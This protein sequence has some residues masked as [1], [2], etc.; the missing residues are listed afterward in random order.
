M[1]DTV[2]NYED[3]S[4]EDF[5]KQPMPEGSVFDE[6]TAPLDED[7]DDQPTSAAAVEN[8]APVGDAPT[9]TEDD[10]PADDA[11]AGD[12]LPQEPDAAATP[13][14]VSED[15]HTTPHH[16]EAGGDDAGKPA[17]APAEEAPNYEALYKAVMAP[18]KA[19]GREVAPTSPEEAV[20]LMQMGAN[21]TRK[22]QS[23]KPNLRMLRMLESNGLLDEDKLSFLIDLDKKQPAA[24][25][26][27]LHDGKVDP[28]DIDPSAAPTYRPGNYKVSDQ[29]MGF[30]DAL[31]TVQ[32]N[33]GGAETIRTV[34]STW[35]Q[36]SK[37]EL[38]G[39][40]SLLVTIDNHRSAGIYDVIAAEV[41]R[42]KLFGDFQ[43]VPFIH[44][45]KAVGDELHTQGKLVPR[46]GPA[47]AAQ[48]P[49]PKPA[50]QALETRPARPRKP[51]VP[52]DAVKAVASAPGKAPASRKSF[53]PLSMSDEEIMAMPLPF[54]A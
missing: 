41:E 1:S 23:L 35:D 3:M 20:R 43:N 53:D 21:Y 15:G 29:E 42:R 51:A 28:M 7:E 22:M 46:G 14:D 49:A 34:N 4:D 50:P 27:L 32:S 47:P 16:P 36:A 30:R 48:T 10:G 44:A 12:D 5:L 11:G 37:N 52:R 38:Y 24:I 19:N 18:F 8:D 45:Y 2:P 9:E 13:S 33:E 6:G 25:Q 54:Q 17:A 39:E 31:E 26:K 40:P